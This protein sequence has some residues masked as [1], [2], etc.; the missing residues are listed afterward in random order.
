MY[1]VF[2]YYKPNTLPK[3]FLSTAKP[4]RTFKRKLKKT[5]AHPLN[6]LYPQYTFF[7]ST[8]SFL[9]KTLRAIESV[10]Q[11]NTCPRLITS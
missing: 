3:N 4:L 2:L 9:K 6:V 11:L 1:N 7:L 5:K 8:E 10:Q